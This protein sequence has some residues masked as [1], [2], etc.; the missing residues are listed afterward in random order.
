MLRMS[1]EHLTRSQIIILRSL[2]KRGAD[3]RAISIE[4][5]QREPAIPLWRRGIVEIWYRQSPDANPSLQGPFYGLTIA[6]AQLALNFLNSRA[7]GNHQSSG[8]E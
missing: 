8:A 1:I 3:N 6:G 2:M 7:S 4:K 5:W